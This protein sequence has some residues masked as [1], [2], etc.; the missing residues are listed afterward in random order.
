MR[1]WLL[2]STFVFEGLCYSE[3]VICWVFFFLTELLKN[4]LIP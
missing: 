4:H 1:V 3:L 2:E